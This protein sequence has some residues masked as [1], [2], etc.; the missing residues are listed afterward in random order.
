MKLYINNIS[1]SFKKNLVLD[2][3]TCELESGK[4][5]GFVGRN[6]CGKTM[7]FRAISGLINVDSG[8]I[9]LE[10]KLLHRDFDVLP[11][12]GM[13]LENAD[14]YPGKS[15]F[16]NLKYLA[17]INNKIDDD[18]IRATISRVGLN[19]DDHKSY[20]KYSLGMK[21][22]LR[23][24]QAVMEAPDIIILDEP[25]NGLDEESVAALRRIVQEEKERG[26][27]ILMA[28]HNR[29]DIESLANEIFFMEQGKI[30]EH[31]VND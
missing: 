28:S 17:G 26:A 1:K 5:Y 23:I 27:M 22:K 25:T 7:L 19:P 11:G 21:Q 16:D 3:I 4:V 8:T 6:G 24:A 30:K 12:L 31:K 15:G 13:V 14:L 9:G 2:D 29:E 18:T 10:D 20:R